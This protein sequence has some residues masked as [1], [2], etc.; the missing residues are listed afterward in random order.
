[1]GLDFIVKVFIQLLFCSEAAQQGSELV[2]VVF[3]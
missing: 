2:A 3:N 1:M